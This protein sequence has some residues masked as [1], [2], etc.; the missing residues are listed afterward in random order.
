MKESEL[1][2]LV[3]SLSPSQIQKVKSQLSKPQNNSKSK[4]DKPTSSKV[5]ELIHRRVEDCGNCGK[6]SVHQS[7]EDYHILENTCIH[8][9]TKK[10]NEDRR[11]YTCEWWSM[12]RKSKLEEGKEA[13]E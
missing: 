5:E 6:S 8:R 9:R 2:G 4:K 11:L 10:Y 1:I 13:E 7:S 3:L 12:K